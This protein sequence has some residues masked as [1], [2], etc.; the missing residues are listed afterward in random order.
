MVVRCDKFVLK[1]ELGKLNQIGEVYEIANIVEDYYVLREEKTK[2]AVATINI[3]ELNEY[4]KPYTPKTNWTKWTPIIDVNGK[5]IGEYK[6]NRK[7]VLF[8]CGN[9]KAEASC[10]TMDEFNLSTGINIAYTRVLLKKYKEMNIESV[11]MINECKNRIS[12]LISRV[13]PLS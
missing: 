4:F 2:I 12:Q 3:L 9:Y 10:N 7:K 13:K 5:M 11:Q 8:K 6:T 1:K